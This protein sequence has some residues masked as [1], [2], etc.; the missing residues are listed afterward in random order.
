MGFEILKRDTNGNKG[1]LNKAEF[2]YDDYPDG[3]DEGRVYIGDG[4]KNRA[5][6]YLDELSNIKMP[7]EILEFKLIKNGSS[8]RYV[9]DEIDPSLTEDGYE[10]FCP[11]SK[12]EYEKARK[13]LLGIGEPSSMGPL[14]IYY[15]EDGPGGAYSWCSECWHSR[16][17]LS[18]NGLG[19][20]GWKVKDGSLTW[21]ASDRTNVT[22]PNGDYKANA[23]L[24]IWY[25]DEGYVRWWNDA[26]DAYSYT[27][28]LCVKRKR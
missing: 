28:Y 10:L 23:Y 13:Y 14:G 24:G 2:G 22:E 7:G 3:G 6:A 20:K 1:L 9:T 5:L 15:S 26:N 11:H 8:L 25:D 16:I 19:S 17:P 18:S 21:W 27:T 4:V 12:E